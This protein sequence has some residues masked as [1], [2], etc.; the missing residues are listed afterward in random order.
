MIISPSNAWI[1][2]IDRVDL[3][4]FISLCSEVHNQFGFQPPVSWPAALFLV[5]LFPKESKICNYHNCNYA[6]N[7]AANLHHCISLFERVHS[8]LRLEMTLM[9]PGVYALVLIPVDTLSV[10]AIFLI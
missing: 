10:C 6:K 9:K 1:E 4:C 2:A 7:I 3:D 5:F 8:S